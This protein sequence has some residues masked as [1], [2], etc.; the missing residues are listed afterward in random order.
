MTSK[1]YA[2]RGFL[3]TELV[4]IYG[5]YCKDLGDPDDIWI[6]GYDEFL[7]YRSDIEIRK[8]EL[9]EELAK[10]VRRCDAIVLNN[11]YQY[12]EVREH[13]TGLYDDEYREKRYPTSHWWWY[14]DRIHFGKLSKPDLSQPI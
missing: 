13:G 8:S 1:L 5:K 4:A 14:A 7:Y 11:A 9:T 10:E 2:S 3:I 6:D 12:I